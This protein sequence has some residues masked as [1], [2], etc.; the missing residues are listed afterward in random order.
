MSLYIGRERCVCVCV[1]PLVVRCVG[2]NDAACRCLNWHLGL[3]VVQHHHK[4][5]C[6]T[7]SSLFRCVPLSRILFPQQK[8]GQWCESAPTTHA[9]QKCCCNLKDAPIR[10][11]DGAILYVVLDTL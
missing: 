8:H 1:C 3:F 4:F 10:G 9:F 11:V 7:D 5:C 2:V 6:D